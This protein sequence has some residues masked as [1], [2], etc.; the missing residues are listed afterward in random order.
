MPARKP[1]SILKIKPDGPLRQTR[2]RSRLNN[3]PPLMK[4][5]D[6]RGRAVDP[7][8]ADPE[9][10]VYQDVVEKLGGRPK[11]KT[12][13]I[14][15]RSPSVSPAP[16]LA[17]V[18]VAAPALVPAA[19]PPS[20]SD[21]QPANSPSSGQPT[22]SSSPVPP[23]P[24]RHSTPP[25]SQSSS[26]GGA[27]PGPSSNS[28][29]SHDS[30]GSGDTTRSLSGDG[31]SQGGN[32][33]YEP[34]SDDSSE[35]LSSTDSSNSP[36]SNGSTSGYDASDEHT[37]G[38][39]GS[40]SSSDSSPC[41]PPNAS[42]SAGSSDSSEGGVPLTG[43]P[44]GGSEE[45]TFSNTSPRLDGDSNSDSS[46]GGA[47]LNGSP[48]VGGD[49]ESLPDYE[50]PPPYVP[51]PDSPANSSPYAVL[52]SIPDSSDGGAPLTDSLYLADNDSESSDNVP[53]HDSP[54]VGSNTSSTFDHLPSASPQHS[55]LVAGFS[56]PRPQTQ[57]TR[58]ARPADV[59]VYPNADTAGMVVQ[60]NSLANESPVN[61][62]SANS[63]HSQ[64][65]VN[66]QN[67]AREAN[68][69]SQSLDTSSNCSGSSLQKRRRSHDDDAHDTPEVETKKRRL[70]TS[71]EAVD[72]A[73]PICTSPDCSGSSPQKRRRSLDDDAGTKRRRL[74]TSS[75]VVEASTYTHTTVSVAAVNDTRTTGNDN[76]PAPT[77]DTP[78]SGGTSP[79]GNMA[80]GTARMVMPGSEQSEGSASGGASPLILPPFDPE[81]PDL[82]GSGLRPRLHYDWYE[83]H[84]AVGLDCAKVH[85]CNHNPGRHCHKCH[86]EWH[87]AW[88]RYFKAEALLNEAAANPEKYLKE[89]GLDMRKG[90]MGALMEGSGW[91]VLAPELKPPAGGKLRI[92][93]ARIA[94]H[95]LALAQL[96]SSE[97]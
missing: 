22:R 91:E 57:G 24:Q 74:S 93:P 6:D 62:T 61:N 45:D 66:Q 44:I 87:K 16:V 3:A 31:S 67:S 32:S 94:K 41:N 23:T 95:K 92:H 78:Q 73:T 8:S 85:G 82:Y 54:Q 7:L 76:S 60:G 97:E 48:L 5:L 2:A 49:D 17:P 81:I 43:S 55:S 40:S 72:A 28:S 88:S 4:G 34:S 64:A 35:S 12:K 52:D 83:Q 18:P 63:N 19:N 84:H 56:T 75:L 68:R 46:G 14:L 58:Q 70:S 86:A 51:P 15:R 89:T 80:S 90:Y 29:P 77:S 21:Q 36:G 50:T 47:P 65:G 53:V 59:L 38:S 25:T 1:K 30:D 71:S 96:A 26:G 79:I 9:A 33:G 69:L 27:A 20:S 37:S 10:L 11:R 39:T 13:I 42:G